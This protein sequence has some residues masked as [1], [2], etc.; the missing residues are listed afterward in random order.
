[1]F[2]SRTEVQRRDGCAWDQLTRNRVLLN[3]D[4]LTHSSL[5]NLR[6]TGKNWPRMASTLGE[7]SGT[8]Q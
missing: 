2:T 4:F 7:C 6:L 3:K 1:M 8:N 5:R